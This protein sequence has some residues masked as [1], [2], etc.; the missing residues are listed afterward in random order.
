MLVRNTWLAQCTARRG[1]DA[2]LLHG[3]P[4]SPGP[5]DKVLGD[6]LESLIGSSPPLSL[7]ELRA[8]CVCL[9]AACCM[10]ACCGARAERAAGL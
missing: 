9:C 6:L 7:V 4:S 10:L 1:L 8:V 2:F 5:E 3:L